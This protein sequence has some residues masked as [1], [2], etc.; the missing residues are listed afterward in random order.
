MICED[1]CVEAQS[2]SGRAGRRKHWVRAWRA[3]STGC[4]C[5]GVS[6]NSLLPLR[7]GDSTVV[8]TRARPS[9]S[10]DRVQL[11][12][13]AGVWDKTLCP[14]GA[15]HSLEVQSPCQLWAWRWGL[16]QVWWMGECDGKSRGPRVRQAGVQN[17][18]QTLPGLWPPV[19]LRVLPV[20]VFS[21]T[22]GW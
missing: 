2:E 14:A 13:R 1:T 20:R 8:S 10:S 19:M 7:P 16:F 21:L 17:L 18:P 22:R 9:L 15:R 12:S 6:L 5:F 11:T 3:E 4:V